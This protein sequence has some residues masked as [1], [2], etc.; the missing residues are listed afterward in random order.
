MG[1]FK[2][3]E[4]ADL[5]PI[6]NVPESSDKDMRPCNG[7]LPVILLIDIGGIRNRPGKALPIPSPAG[8]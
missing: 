4:W 8:L 3:T 6:S 7:D 1:M 5:N 2:L